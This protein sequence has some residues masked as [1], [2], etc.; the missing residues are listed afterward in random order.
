[1]MQSGL[2]FILFYFFFTA[3]AE[4]SEGGNIAGGAG[5]AGDMEEITIMKYIISFRV[6]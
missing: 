3:P 4:L 1:M 5:T 2:Y 6:I